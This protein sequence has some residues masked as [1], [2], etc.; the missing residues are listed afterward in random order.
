MGKLTLTNG[1]RVS[2][3]FEVNKAGCEEP[4]EVA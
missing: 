1:G 3:D 2:A 4:W